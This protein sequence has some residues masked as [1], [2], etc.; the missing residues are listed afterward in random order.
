MEYRQDLINLRQ[1]LG[2]SVLRISTSS[3][4]PPT[5]P[6]T[7]LFTS[8]DKMDKKITCYLDCV[9]PYSYHAFSYLQK[10]AAALADLGVEIEYVS[11]QVV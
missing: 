7:I 5:Y 2:I 11:S 1:C 6:Q 4:K 3:I 10:N 9:S 8:L